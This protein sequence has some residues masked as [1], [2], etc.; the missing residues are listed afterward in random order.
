MDEDI[1]EID[2]GRLN[3]QIYTILLINHSITAVKNLSSSHYSS[4]CS[5]MPPN[6]PVSIKIV[7]VLIFFMS[8]ITY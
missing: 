4:F 1:C 2:F 3:D 7:S 5:F 6:F 8:K